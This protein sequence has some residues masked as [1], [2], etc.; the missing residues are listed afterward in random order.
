[1]DKWRTITN[2]ELRRYSKFM[3]KAHNAVTELYKLAEQD[4]EHRSI[5]FIVADSSQPG[6][7]VWKHTKCGVNL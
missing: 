7:Q 5:L 2:E 6:G 3:R 4:P 1:M